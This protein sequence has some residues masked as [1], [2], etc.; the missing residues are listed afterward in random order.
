MTD[1]LL[2][3]LGGSVARLRMPVAATTAI[4]EQLGAPT[5]G[6]ADLPLS[7]AAFRKVR[8]AVSDGNQ[9]KYELLISAAAVEAQVSQLGLSS[10]EVLFAMGL[11]ITV[12]KEFFVIEGVS[13]TSAAGLAC[14][15]R[16]LLREAATQS[17]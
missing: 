11:G 12:G 5:A 1:A 8:V 6:F 3:S 15:Y 14:V 9:A 13:F 16:V 17:Y 4:G 2:R 7:P 10:A